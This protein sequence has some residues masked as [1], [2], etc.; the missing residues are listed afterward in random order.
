[1]AAPVAASAGVAAALP[2]WA[3]ASTILVNLGI[4]GASANAEAEANSEEEDAEEDYAEEEYAE[5]EDDSVDQ[6]D[7][8]PR[9]SKRQCSHT[10]NVNMRINGRYLRNGKCAYDQDTLTNSGNYPEDK[11]LPRQIRQHRDKD[12]GMAPF[13][14]SARLARYFSESTLGPL[15]Q[16][17]VYAVD[18]A[19]ETPQPLM[20]SSP[21]TTSDSTLK[22]TSLISDGNPESTYVAAAPT[23]IPSTSSVEGLQTFSSGFC[24]GIAL[25]AP[26]ILVAVLCRIFILKRA[27]KQRRAARVEHELVGPYPSPVVKTESDLESGSI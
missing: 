21:A 17:L 7:A 18:S 10:D 22:L 5:G 24:G 20:N 26:I 13:Q 3:A 11:M 25:G 6:L 8:K 19:G 2:G 9:L 4:L 14:S 1:M 27:N 15:M 23:A 12:E 16:S